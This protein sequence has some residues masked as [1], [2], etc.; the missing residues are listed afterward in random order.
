MDLSGNNPPGIEVGNNYLVNHVRLP[1]PD[2]LYFL[3][4][5]SL[6]FK[7]PY[8]FF[9]SSPSLELLLTCERKSETGV[10]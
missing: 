6:F 10:V 2:V 1:N 7:Y 5:F 4:L 8:R 9:F 3:E